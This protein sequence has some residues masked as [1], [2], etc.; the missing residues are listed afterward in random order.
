[1][2]SI[3]QTDSPTKFPQADDLFSFADYLTGGLL[4]MAVAGAGGTLSPLCDGLVVNVSTR[5]GVFVEALLNGRHVFSYARIEPKFPLP[6]LN[7]GQ[8]TWH[9]VGVA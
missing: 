2:S 4:A 8:W 9:G 5:R 3:P 1:M 6:P 7:A